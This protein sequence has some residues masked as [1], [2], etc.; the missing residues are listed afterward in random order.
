[1]K[2]FLE[3]ATDFEN[4]LSHFV[5]VLAVDSVMMAVEEC[6]F[7]IDYQEGNFDS[8]HSEHYLMEF[9]NQGLDTVD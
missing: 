9:A 1:M 4:Q 5:D 3:S 7:E 8:E 6:L 2:C